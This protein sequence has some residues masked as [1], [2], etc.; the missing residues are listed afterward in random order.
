MDLP[1]LYIM[2]VGQNQYVT[3]FDSPKA[4]PN[5]KVERE[6][7]LVFSAKSDIPLARAACP[8]EIE[9][10]AKLYTES[11]KNQKVTVLAVT[12]E[13][14]DLLDLSRL[15]CRPDLKWDHRVLATH[16]LVRSKLGIPPL[17]LNQ[18]VNGIESYD[19]FDL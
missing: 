5:V 16:N 19:P 14:E 6:K 4:H 3:F 12:G 17:D 2:P 10:L 9:K 15:V 13:Q 11:K 1:S 18:S 8:V 7:E